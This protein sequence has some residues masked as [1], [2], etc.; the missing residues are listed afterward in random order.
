[1]TQHKVKFVDLGRQYLALKPEI[2]MAIKR[3]VDESAFILGKEVSDFETNFKK[4]D[5]QQILY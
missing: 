3:V 1:M 5:W 2:D 4:H